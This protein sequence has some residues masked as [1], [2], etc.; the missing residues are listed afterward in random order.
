MKNNSERTNTVLRH[1]DSTI[2]KLISDGTDIDSLV[3]KLE[4]K[5]SKFEKTIT[6]C[7]P[8]EVRYKYV[9]THNEVC[10]KRIND[11]MYAK[12]LM[13]E[14][15]EYSKYSTSKIFKLIQFRD[16]LFNPFVVSIDY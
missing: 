6:N 15:D 13:D 8:N 4:D 2:V 7:N 9:F 12:Q 14:Y 10:R 16:K 5:L 1:I 3:S 11:L